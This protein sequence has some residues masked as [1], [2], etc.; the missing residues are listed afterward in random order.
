MNRFFLLILV[1][2]AVFFTLIAS[3]G[4]DSSDVE[5][6]SASLTGHLADLVLG[7]VPRDHGL[8]ILYGQSYNHED[9]VDFLQLNYQSIY[10]FR[11][12]W[13]FEPPAETKFKFEYSA[14]S[15]LRVEPR[16]IGSWAMLVMWF[17]ECLQTDLFSPYLEGGAGI[18]YTDFRADGQ[19]LR[20]NFCPQGGVGTLIHAG[21]GAPWFISC[22]IHHISNSGLD[23]ENGGV[24]SVLLLVGRYF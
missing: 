10:E 15:R 7:R 24:D 12:V 11:D 1:H 2:W 5:S 8:G 21:D 19:G 3:A 23:R 6:S 16:F 20:W 18:I 14:G 22:R 4:S 13:R 17:P 9:E